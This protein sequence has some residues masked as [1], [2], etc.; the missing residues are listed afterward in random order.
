MKPSM[1]NSS[2]FRYIEKSLIFEILLLST[3]FTG[4]FFLKLS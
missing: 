2:I 1:S 4:Y 3:E